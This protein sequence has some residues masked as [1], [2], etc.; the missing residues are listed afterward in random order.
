MSYSS[1]LAAAASDIGV[2]DDG[3]KESKGSN[4]MVTEEDDE[5]EEDNDDHIPRAAYAPNDPPHVPDPYND[6]GRNLVND[7][8]LTM[9]I[10]ELN[11]TITSLETWAAATEDEIRIERARLDEALEAKERLASEYAYAARRSVDLEGRLVD[12]DEHEKSPDATSER[13]RPL[14]VTLRSANNRKRRLKKER[15]KARRK[16]ESTKG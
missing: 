6:P 5:E 9:Q 8:I 4:S 2:N 1:S 3:N 10:A 14:Q 12:E 13:V 11:D 16:M 15:D 7:S